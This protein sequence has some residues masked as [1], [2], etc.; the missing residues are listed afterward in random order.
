MNSRQ[1]QVL[2]S[3]ILLILSVIFLIVAVVFFVKADKNKKK[4]IKEEE[5]KISQQIAES[6][7]AQEE[8][9]NELITSANKIADGYDYE[10][11]INL[12]KS[13]EGYGQ[14]QEVLDAIAEYEAKAQT[15]VEYPDVTTITHVFFHSLIVDTDKAF[16]GEYTQDGYNQ[17]MTT[18][19]EFN[20][21]MEQMYEKGYVLVSIKDVATLGTDENGVEK[22]MPGKIMLPEGKIP[23]V[24]SVD[25]VSYYEYM[26]GD[27]FANRLV[28][29]E[30]GRPTNEMDMEDG[31]VQRGDFDVVSC[32]ET[33][34]E[35]HPDF[36]YKGARGILAL[37]GYDGVLGYRT[38]PSFSELP[39]YN[40]QIEKA[41]QVAEGLKNW[42]W[43]FA[44]HSYGHIN[45]GEISMERLQADATKWQ[46]TVASIIGDTDILIYPFGADIGDWHDYSGEK[47]DY[48]KSMGFH[49]FCNV[50]SA[51]AW[52]QL[53]DNYV[54]QG[55]RNL[56]GDRMY[57]DMIHEDQD[58]LS[59][60][61]DVSSVFDEARPLP[62]PH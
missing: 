25:D 50:D 56:D 53:R 33:F 13:E 24:L 45:Y 17:V 19:D 21:I 12:L 16:D 60:L 55:R 30:D 11:A 9:W 42:G 29:Q 31:S 10:K 51:P 3:R 8:K 5:Q 23:F 52:V 43:E 47:F 44:S 39:D 54:R 59:D 49:Y 20:K 61:F 34:I 58:Y 37:T 38:D 41:K 7:S 40:E 1:K 27:G 32:L 22:Y 26:E 36:S 28:I 6:E 18:V 62:V 2:L 14:S 4:Q 35:N 15:L 46:D 57:Q 48:L